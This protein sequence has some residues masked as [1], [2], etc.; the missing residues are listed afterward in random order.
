MLVVAHRHEQRPSS[1]LRVLQCLLRGRLQRLAAIALKVASDP[2]IGLRSDFAAKGCDS[3]VVVDRVRS[4]RQR[5]VRAAVL[6]GDHGHAR[7]R[8][9]V[10]R[11]PHLGW[12]RI[13][14]DH[15]DSLG[16]FALAGY[17]CALVHMDSM[18]RD[19]LLAALAFRVA[20]ECAPLPRRASPS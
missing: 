12:L 6:A 9:R 14:C 5:R 16:L 17:Q 19:P 11:V 13:W 1:S 15:V 3:P 18:H 4:R 20:A 8:W 2:S 7:C 10:E